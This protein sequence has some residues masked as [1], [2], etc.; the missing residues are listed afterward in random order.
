MGFV[1]LEQFNGEPAMPFH[2]M[3]VSAY[4]PALKKWRQTWVDDEGNYLDFA[5]EFRDDRMVLARTAVEEGGEDQAE[6]GVVQH[7]SRFRSIGIGSARKM[8][9]NLG[10][11]SG[12]STISAN[13]PRAFLPDD[14]LSNLSLKA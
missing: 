11:T 14:P 3:S 5:G 7:R 6:D 12:A 2:G 9:A 4:S 13:R 1:V 8:Q 10:R